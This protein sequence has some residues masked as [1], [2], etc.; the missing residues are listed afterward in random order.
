MRIIIVRKWLAFIYLEM[1]EECYMWLQV[2]LEPTTSWGLVR[3]N[4]SGASKYTGMV[5]A[6]KDIFREEGFRVRLLNISV[7]W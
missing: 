6:T 5:Q 4:L 1:V 3:G 2:Q 7:F